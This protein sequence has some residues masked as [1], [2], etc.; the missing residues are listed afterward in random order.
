MNEKEILSLA[1]TKYGREAQTN[2]ALEEMGE[3]ISAINQYRR[4]RIKIDALRE[5][6]ADVIIMATQMAM[7]YGPCAVEQKKT[8]KILRL[9]NR[10]QDKKCQ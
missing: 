8:D 4:G 5:E 1:I 3:L 2:M 7:M 6:I 10:L 9:K